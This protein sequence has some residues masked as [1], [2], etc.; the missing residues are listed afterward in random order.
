MKM[1]AYAV[2]VR[3]VAGAGLGGLQRAPVALGVVL[4]LCV[5]MG[6]SDDD[7]EPAVVAGDSGTVT[8]LG[9]NMDVPTTAAVRGGNAWVPQ[10]QFDHLPNMANMDVD[11]GPFVVSGVSLSGGTS[12]GSISLPADFFPE[13]I[14]ADP[15]TGELYVGSITTGAIVKVGAGT[16]T[17]AAWLATG[18]LT[19]G[20]VGMTVDKERDLLWVCDSSLA[21]MGG[22]LVGID[23]G[24]K[25]VKVK[26]EMA[27]MGFCNDVVVDDDGTVYVTETFGGTVSKIEPADALTANSA[28]V[29]LTIPEIAPPP[30]GFGA[31]G[32]TI[33]GQRMFIANTSTPQLVR[34]DYKAS[35]PA[36]TAD[37]VTLTE[38]GT[39]YTLSGPDGLTKLSENELLVVENSFAGPMRPRV[40]KVTLDTE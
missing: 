20:A 28:D 34:V 25:S 24:D 29:W 14:A 6:C 1:K 8:V 31:N 10:G 7:E 16:T 40:T 23:L 32:I 18:V 33:L 19:R 26:H 4:G 5:S 27:A 21:T 38:N 2:S 37:V 15:E 9:D 30:M 11:P 17:A 12:P 35:N 36:S 13:G 39:A 22:T 3:S